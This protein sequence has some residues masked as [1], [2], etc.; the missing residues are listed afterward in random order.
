MSGGFY[1]INNPQLSV[2]CSQ[3]GF[4][5]MGATDPARSSMSGQSKLSHKHINQTGTASTVLRCEILAAANWLKMYM[6]RFDPFTNTRAADAHSR[7]LSF[8]NF[9]QMFRRSQL[10]E[11]KIR[12]SVFIHHRHER[13][14][15]RERREE[16]YKGRHWSLSLH[17]GRGGESKL[18]SKQHRRGNSCIF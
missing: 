12:P 1:S 9:P 15:Q 8:S 16:I 3:G 5:P 6:F 11:K 18:S 13:L 10:R 4:P 17:L 14:S 7:H 2:G